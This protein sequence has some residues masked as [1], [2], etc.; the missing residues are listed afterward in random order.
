MLGAVNWIPRWYNA[1]GPASSQQV[2]DRFA[3]YL[4]GGLAVAIIEGR[5]PASFPSPRRARAS[6]SPTG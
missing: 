4:I 6:P 1:E 2:A 3:D 5:C